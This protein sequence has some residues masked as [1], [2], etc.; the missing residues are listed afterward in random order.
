MMTYYWLF[1]L[2]NTK[3]SQTRKRPRP[4]ESKLHV[5][6][7]PVCDILYFADSQV[8]IEVRTVFDIE[9]DYSLVKTKLSLLKREPTMATQICSMIFVN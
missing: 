1:L 2:Q 4:S 6:V 8:H 7:M 9:K 5:Y 3:K